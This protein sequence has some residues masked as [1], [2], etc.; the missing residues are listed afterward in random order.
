[1]ADTN[2]PAFKKRVKGALKRQH[3]HLHPPGYRAEKGD[4]DG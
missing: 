1:G 4:S 2:W 3:E